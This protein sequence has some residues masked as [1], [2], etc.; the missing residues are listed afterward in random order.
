MN[1]VQCLRSGKGLQH[2]I[3]LTGEVNADGRHNV[4]LI[5]AN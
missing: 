1:D 4:P 2:I 3:S 5:I